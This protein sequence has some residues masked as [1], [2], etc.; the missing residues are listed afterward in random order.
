ME[1]RRPDFRRIK[2]R[3]SLMDVLKRYDVQLRAANQHSWIGKCPMPQHTSKDTDTF[4]VTR[5]TKGWGWACHSASC[6]AARNTS[7]SDGNPKKGGDLIEF[8]KFMEQLS[9]LR[10]AGVR[11]EEWYGPFD[12]TVQPP[13][14]KV[15]AVEV[16]EET[17]D[18]E[19]LKFELKAIEHTHPFL[20]VRGFD[21]EECE[22]LGVGFFPGKGSMRNRIVF[23]LHNAEGQLI[24]YA[25]R[26]VEYSLHDDDPTHIAP[27]CPDLERWKFPAN[28]KRGRVLYNLHRVEGDSVIV[29]ES[30]WGVMA[31]I[32]AGVMNAVA[33]MSNNITDAQAA[34]LAARFKHVTVMLDGDRPGREG[35]AQVLGRLVAADVENF[36]LAMLP[37]D[38]QP[39]TVSP[40]E[41]RS[42]LH[43]PPVPDGSLEVIEEHPYLCAVPAS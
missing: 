18:N 1:E 17:A 23:P 34:L 12:V 16:V 21:E 7:K 20:T 35:T 26:R 11:L 15:D 29:V 10:Q 8:V 25:G 41:L 38:R 9:S 42:F 14:P 33:I 39:D 40:D 36:E 43:L 4:K 37:A 31:C 2:E 32:R 6:I 27:E 5:G 3:V 22:Y 28:F 13:A 30:F 24:G 19:P